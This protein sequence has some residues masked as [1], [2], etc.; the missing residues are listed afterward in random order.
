MKLFQRVLKSTIL[1][2]PILYRE[3]AGKR[4][5]QLSYWVHLVEGLYMKY[6]AAVKEKVPGQHPPDNIMMQ[7]MGK[8]ITYQQ[9]R[10]SR[11]REDVL[12]VLST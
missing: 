11:H 2:S 10:S 5:K 6:R 8:H 9:A 7:L 12:C 1:N 4:N 3:N